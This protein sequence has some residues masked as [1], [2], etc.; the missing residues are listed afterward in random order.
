MRLLFTALGGGG[1]FHPLV[2]IAQA[3]QRAGH[4][5]AFAS[6]RVEVI[7]SAEHYGFAAFRVGYDRRGRGNLD[8]FPGFAKQ[9][10]R[11]LAYWAP[12]Q[13]F[14]RFIATTA[15]PDLVQVCREWQPDLIVRETAEYSGCV[16]AELL[17]IPHASVRSDSVTASYGLRHLTHAALADL[18]D[19][20]GLPPDPEMEMPFRYLHLACEPPGF[21]TDGDSYAPTAHLLQPESFDQPHGE[22]LPAW[23]AEMPDQPTVYASLGT[24]VS[25]LPE[26]RPIF[27]SIVNAF[28]DQPL[29]LILTIGRGGNTNQFGPLPPNIR[30]AEYIPQTL[31]F[32]FCDAV[33]HHSGFNTAAAALNC[34]LPMVMIPVS[35]DQFHNTECVIRLGAG[36]ELDESQRTTEAIRSATRTVLSDPAYRNTAMTVRDQTAALPGSEHA[37]SLLE[38]LAQDRRPL[39]ARHQTM[40]PAEPF[41]LM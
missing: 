28:R 32:Q 16:V 39:I 8:L 31:V 27:T 12:S 38:Q 7:A 40:Q 19:L 5:V 14:I 6:G 20:M 2:P 10:H 21:L 1:H 35:A 17:D 4:D 24:F 36:I 25:K 37:V 34:G 18:R 41:G 13:L 26:G 33:I 3:A 9:P 15:T 30:V 23:V 22:D 11:T 29:N